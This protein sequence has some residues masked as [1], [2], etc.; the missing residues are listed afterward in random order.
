MI[1]R[2]RISTLFPYTTLFRSDHQR[3]TQRSFVGGS[4]IWRRRNC[5]RIETSLYHDW[6]GCSD[7]YR[8]LAISVEPAGNV[9]FQ[10][11]VKVGAAKAKC[12]EAGAPRGIRGNRPR[13]QLS[14][15]IEGR[16][17]KVDRRIGMLAIHAGR[18]YFVAKR[19]GRLQQSS[20]ARSSF[21]M[22]NVR[23]DRAQRHRPSGKMKTAEH[24]SHAL[25]LDGVAH[26]S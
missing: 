25:Q 3:A 13:T 18:Q 23:F 9:L 7:S 15:D 8:P 21:E 22:P 10:H 12:A 4:R 20:R 5:G 17:S 26:A 2:P 14:I 1:R 19:Q 6:R 11:S 16:V 24:F